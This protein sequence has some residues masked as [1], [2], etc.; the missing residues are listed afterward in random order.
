MDESFL[1]Y[2]LKFG[3]FLLMVI[4]TDAYINEI[5]YKKTKFLSAVL[6]L[7]SIYLLFD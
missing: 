2:L 6:C 7:G 1:F 3:F 4:F 5:I